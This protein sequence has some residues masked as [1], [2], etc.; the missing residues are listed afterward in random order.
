MGGVGQ[1]WKDRVLFSPLFL[2]FQLF[3]K[4]KRQGGW[5]K[6]KGNHIQTPILSCT[7]H[8]KGYIMSLNMTS[9]LSKGNLKYV[10]LN[11]SWIHCML[12]IFLNIHTRGIQLKTERKV[13][14]WYLIPVTNRKS[15]DKF[16][17]MWIEIVLITFH[18]TCGVLS[19]YNMNVCM[20]VTFN[21]AVVG[22]LSVSIF[23]I[24]SFLINFLSH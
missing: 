5:K 17:S 22:K 18:Q 11:F 7:R 9:Y 1:S 20:Y 10:V 12:W 16:Q 6:E 13:K 4:G 24:C 21:F 19:I 23:V 2:E 3:K 15:K 14:T 8:W